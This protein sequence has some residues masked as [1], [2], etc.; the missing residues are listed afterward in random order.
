MHSLNVQMLTSQYGSLEFCPEVV[1][2][3]IVEVDCLSMNDEVRNRL[4]YLGHI[5]IS[6]QFQ[7]VEIAL[8]ENLV[9]TDI[10]N[11]FHGEFTS[12]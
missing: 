4:R 12:S 11:E 1:E 7:I 10:L 6:K 2:G 8:D 9:D 5:P 3:E